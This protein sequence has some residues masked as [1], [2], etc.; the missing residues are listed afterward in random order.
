MA[1]K[2][3][4]L[5]VKKVIAET[6]ETVSLVFE[7]PDDL[8]SIFKYKQG[9]YLTLKFNID[10]QEA[11]RAYSMSSSPLE[12]DLKVTVKR[13]KNGLVSN[14]IYN[15]I[16]EE[17]EVEVMSP[18]GRFYTKT[19]E[20]N[21]KTYYLFAAGSGITPVISIIKTLLEAEPQ[22][23]LFLLYGNRNEDQII[24]NEELGQL[25]KRYADQFYVEHT[26]SQPKQEKAGG[27][28]S[29][30]KK[31][32]MSWPGWKGRIDTSKVKEFLLKYPAR[33]KDVEYFICGPNPLMESVKD[34]LN[35]EGVDKKNI[36]FEVFTSA[37][38]GAESKGNGT[39]VATD[40]R[41]VKVQ[42]EGQW[43]TVD[44]KEKE[45]ILDAL[46]R[47]DHN[48]P[49]SCT[50]GACSTCMAKVVKGKVEM[51]VCYALDDDEVEEGYILTCQ[52]KPTEP[53]T[54]ITYEI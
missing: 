28:G 20:D 10:G 6:P 1:N 21:R 19:N 35:N 15:K 31:P 13:V 34:H 29:W 41:S 22:S 3:Y 27:L 53:G 11:R 24:F 45:T 46:L 44:L 38:P 40:A 7:V 14:F 49:F 30:F 54:E 12:P 36:H 43:V 9:Q 8:K 32:R 50:S 33:N 47:M 5:K 39:T 17:S 51:E 26:L 2:F 4:K 52:A 18:E 25:T 23:T 48:P 37:L 16:K 42:L